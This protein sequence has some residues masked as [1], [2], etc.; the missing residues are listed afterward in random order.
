MKAIE[1][2]KIMSEIARDTVEGIDD[3]DFDK[4]LTEQGFDSLDV[5]SFFLEVETKFNVS[6]DDADLEVLNTID[7][8]AEYVRSKS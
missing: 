2:K 1:I 6:I 5:N 4:P 3:L 8:V 7:K